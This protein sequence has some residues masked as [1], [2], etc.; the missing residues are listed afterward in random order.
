[1]S[2]ATLTTDEQVNGGRRE[3]KACL[4]V[5]VLKFPSTLPNA[6]FGACGKK[7]S[8]RKV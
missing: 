6:L 4:L 1:M 7:Y 2:Q 3:D 8:T 5:A